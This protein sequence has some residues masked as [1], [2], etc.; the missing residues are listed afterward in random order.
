MKVL[1][2]AIDIDSVYNVMHGLDEAIRFTVKNN[3]CYKL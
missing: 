3:K 2:L 1:K